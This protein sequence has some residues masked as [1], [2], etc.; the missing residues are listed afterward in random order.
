MNR[1]KKVFICG[2][3]SIILLVCAI[4]IYL[5]GLGVIHAEIS[6]PNYIKSQPKQ[7]F[8][9][10]FYR[11][12]ITSY[13]TSLIID[14][15][16]VTAYYNIFN[17]EENYAG[18]WE[19]EL[20]TNQTKTTYNSYWDTPLSSLP[21]SWRNDLSIEQGRITIIQ[22]ESSL[23]TYDI[24]KT[25]T[26]Y[27]DKPYFTVEITKTYRFDSENLNNQ[28]IVDVQNSGFNLEI[29][30]NTLTFLLGDSRLT[31]QIYES[32]KPAS[33]QLPTETTDYTEAQINIDGQS[34]RTERSHLEG[35]KETVKLKVTIVP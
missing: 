24:K 10:S 12:E 22:T 6:Y 8:E 1:N 17:C 30:K 21:E 28:I 19:L 29:H 32:S 18:N 2:T 5:I 13:I 23:L 15:T 9:N 4:A 16:D 3:V 11:V 26:L 7:T 34:D 35:E 20:V 25:W 27:Q 31:I 33:W 14:G